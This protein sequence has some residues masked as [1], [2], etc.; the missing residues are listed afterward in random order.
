MT[1]DRSSVHLQGGIIPADELHGEATKQLVQQH[2]L[3]KHHTADRCQPVATSGADFLYSTRHQVASGRTTAGARRWMVG[4]DGG[5]GKIWFTELL[6]WVR[7]FR[8]GIVHEMETALSRR[9]E[10]SFIPSS[11]C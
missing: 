7:L 11:C 2:L 9:R 1:V 5:I 6:F 3:Q 8:A 4:L 10:S